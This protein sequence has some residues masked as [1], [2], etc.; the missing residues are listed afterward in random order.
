MQNLAAPDDFLN[1]LFEQRQRFVTVFGFDF[2]IG[3]LGNLGAKAPILGS[4]PHGAS[5]I[6]SP[7][8]LQPLQKLF[9]LS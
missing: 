5:H 7:Q 3:Q 4:K 6:S 2:D 1:A 8:R 9:A